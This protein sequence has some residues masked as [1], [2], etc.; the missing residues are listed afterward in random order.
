MD[1]LFSFRK[2]R[3]GIESRVPDHEAHN[4]V[5]RICLSANKREL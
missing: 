5:S 4:L 3:H 2:G 1:L